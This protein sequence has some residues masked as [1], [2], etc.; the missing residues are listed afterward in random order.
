ML[1]SVESMKPYK[2]IF[3]KIIVEEVGDRY[4]KNNLVDYCKW[5]KD[6]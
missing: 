1:L 6:N 5:I 2:K 3:I 4:N